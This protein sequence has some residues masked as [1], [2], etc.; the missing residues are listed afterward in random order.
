MTEAKRQQTYEYLF[1]QMST[2]TGI[3]FDTR[4]CP[5]Y[6]ILEFACFLRVTILSFRRHTDATQYLFNK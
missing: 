3:P 6:F 1:L 5:A 4:L 2:T